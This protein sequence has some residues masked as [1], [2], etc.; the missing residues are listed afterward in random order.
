MNFPYICPSWI[1]WEKHTDSIYC[2]TKYERV[3]RGGTSIPQCETALLSSQQEKTLLGTG[4]QFNAFE[5]ANLHFTDRD[6]K[7]DG[8]SNFIQF[9]SSCCLILIFSHSI[10]QIWWEYV[11]DQK[12]I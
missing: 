8:T 12:Q 6:K 10:A 3:N 5:L 11:G 9:L 4:S 2:V 7:V 1:C